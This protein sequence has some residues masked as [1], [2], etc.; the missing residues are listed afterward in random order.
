MKKLLLVL[1]VAALTLSSCSKEDV[2]E[3]LPCEC[4]VLVWEE[5]GQ[6]NT[7]YEPELDSLIY[8]LKD[9]CSDSEEFESFSSNILSISID[10][11]NEDYR[12]KI[13]I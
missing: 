13:N 6:Y 4:T 12:Y 7:I 8:E 11:G 1:S 10:C 9:E 2:P 3:V 5:H